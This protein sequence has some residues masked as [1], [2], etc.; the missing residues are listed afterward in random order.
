M[1][2]CPKCNHIVEDA[3]GLTTCDKCGENFFA[4]ENIPPDSEENQDFAVDEPKVNETQG[5]VSDV[6]ETESF[7]EEKSDL[8]KDEELGDFVQEQNEEVATSFEPEESQDLE[9]D[10]ENQNMDMD[11]ALANEH[12][13]SEDLNLDS[14]VE[15]VQNSENSENEI[16]YEVEISGIDSPSIKEKVLSTL[17]DPRL[18]WK[19]E[20]LKIE[21]GKLV[22]NKLKSTKAYI[23]VN[24]LKGLEVKISWKQ[25]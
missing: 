4:G 13:V 1:A 18:G 11:E 16:F 14:I 9:D 24:S 15:E 6:N 21:M 19:I 5:F 23:V 17:D 12:E 22:L 3:F 2:N 10:F 20:D 7:I 25:L 8:K